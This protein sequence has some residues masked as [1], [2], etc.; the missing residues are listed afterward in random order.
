[1]ALVCWD[2]VRCH[3]PSVKDSKQ[4]RQP[5]CTL[6][7]LRHQISCDL[8]AEHQLCVGRHKPFRKIT[9][10]HSCGP[11]TSWLSAPWETGQMTPEQSKK[12]KQGTS[13]TGLQCR[14][15]RVCQS[16]KDTALKHRFQTSGEAD[17]WG[18]CP[19]ILHLFSYA[20]LVSSCV[21]D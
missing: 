8:P 14:S 5:K 6:K 19:H 15:V 21:S 11:G 12:Q 1:M 4:L 18:S 10:H 20:N 7:S 3:P 17:S 2:D 13:K 16:G 9:F